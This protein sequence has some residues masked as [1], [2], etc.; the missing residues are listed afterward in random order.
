MESKAAKLPIVFKLSLLSK[1]M[2]YFGY[3]HEWKTILELISKKTR[4]I[5]NDNTKIFM[6]WG[7]DQRF[8]VHYFKNDSNKTYVQNILK[9]AELFD[10]NTE[11]FFNFHHDNS[12]TKDIKFQ[13]IEWM[14]TPFLKLLNIAN[15]MVIDRSSKQYHE[16]IFWTQNEAEDILY[17][18]LWSSP[19]KDI[20]IFDSNQRKDLL[21]YISEKVKYRRIVIRNWENNLIEVLSIFSNWPWYSENYNILN[22]EVKVKLNSYYSCTA[23]NWAWKPNSLCIMRDSTSEMSKET[24]NEILKLSVLENVTR[25]KI[26][27]GVREF[28]SID[29]LWRILQRFPKL[30]IWFNLH[31]KYSRAKLLKVY[32][33]KLDSNVVNLIS[34][35]KILSLENNYGSNVYIEGTF[36]RI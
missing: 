34:N 26:N 5:W 16:I 22:E 15:A 24:I 10:I 17:S 28:S 3:L 8:N 23:F 12:C 14:F 4:K 2:P 6:Y 30:R 20:K 11:W 19:L 27:P 7:R 25:L 1:I 21:K 13:V 32:N 31:Y 9:N 33:I 18:S 35:D 36:F 29:N